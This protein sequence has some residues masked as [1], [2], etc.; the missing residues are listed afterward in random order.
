MS[1][2]SALITLAGTHNTY[3]TIFVAVAGALL[4][5]QTSDKAFTRLVPTRIGICAIFIVF[6]AANC[7]VIDETDHA[8]RALLRQVEVAHKAKPDEVTQYHLT[9]A[10]RLKATDCPKGLIA[11]HIALDALVVTGLWFLPAF[12]STKEDKSPKAC[13]R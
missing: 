10:R 12:A 5:Y 11:L 3:W 2:I 9:A 6:A 13:S 1:E 8:R 4:T 7:N